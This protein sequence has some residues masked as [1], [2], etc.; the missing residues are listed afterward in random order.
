[1]SNSD[2][3]DYLTGAG[4]KMLKVVRLSSV[5]VPNRSFKLSV[6]PADYEKVFDEE[7]WEEGT[8]VREWGAHGRP[9]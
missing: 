1:M 7:L 3:I 2:I 9:Y 8:R 6:S 5:N 4:I